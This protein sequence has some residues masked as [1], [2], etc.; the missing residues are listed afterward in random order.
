[1]VPLGKDIAD[2]RRLRLVFSIYKANQRV[3]VLFRISPCVSVP[4]SSSIVRLGRGGTFKFFGI[5]A[6][7]A[8][9][10]LKSLFECSEYLLVFELR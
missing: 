10:P 5:D 6:F 1:M 3:K 4:S 9:P 7:S 2:K 8:Q